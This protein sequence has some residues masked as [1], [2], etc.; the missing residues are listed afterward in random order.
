[1][2]I[3][4][5]QSVVAVTFYQN[6]IYKSYQ[7][8]I[9]NVEYTAKRDLFGY[10]DLVQKLMKEYHNMWQLRYHICTDHEIVYVHYNNFGVVDI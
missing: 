6:I 10:L 4:H 7:F 2:Y 5:D 3:K 9:C 1:M 8:M